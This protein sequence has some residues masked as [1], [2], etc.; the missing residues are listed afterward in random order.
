MLCPLR[1]AVPCCVQMIFLNAMFGYLCF[2]ILL[3]WASGSTADLYHILIY[4]F[5]DVSGLRGGKE[6]GGEEH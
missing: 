6:R 3:K 1:C 5:L 4:M 2:L